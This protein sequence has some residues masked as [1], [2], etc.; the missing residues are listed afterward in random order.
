MRR[1]GFAVFLLTVLAL[2]LVPALYADGALHA[3]A[4]PLAVRNFPGAAPCNTTLAACVS[5]SNAGDVISVAQ[6]L[7]LSPLVVISHHLSLQ[8]HGPT[9]SIVASNGAHGVISISA[10]IAAGVVLSGLAVFAGASS[11]AGGGV[12]ADVGSPVSL[13]NVFVVSNTSTSIGGG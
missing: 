1:I 3:S 6:G 7:F 9:L 12:A 4:A 10:N 2:A 5:G 11:M 8:G 13:F